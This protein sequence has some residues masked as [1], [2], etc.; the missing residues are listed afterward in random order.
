MPSLPG[1]DNEPPSGRQGDRQRGGG[2]F[3]A[4]SSNLDEEVFGWIRTMRDA[5]RG[6]CSEQKAKVRRGQVGWASG[7][8]P[9][10]VQGPSRGVPHH[11]WGQG[12]MTLRAAS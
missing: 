4:V 6:R 12:A 7:E 8:V 3:L 1:Q 11:N 5:S 9:R 10:C 2:P